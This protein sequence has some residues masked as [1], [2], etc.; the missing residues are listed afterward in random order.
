MFPLGTSGRDS[1]SSSGSFYSF[2]S[3]VLHRVSFAAGYIKNCN[4]LF[5]TKPRS[6]DCC[7]RLKVP[8]IQVTVWSP[9]TSLGGGSDACWT[10]RPCSH[11]MFLNFLTA[12]LSHNTQ[13]DCLGFSSIYL[14]YPCLSSFFLPASP[15]VEPE[16]SGEEGTIPPISLNPSVRTL[17]VILPGWRHLFLKQSFI[18]PHT[19]LSSLKALWLL[20]FLCVFNPSIYTH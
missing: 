9:E 19:P 12:S 16:T 4:L 11:C 18:F 5:S 1:S 15:P 10:P 6:H 20:L 17:T 2:L 7:L 14:T 3:A 13:F 8:S